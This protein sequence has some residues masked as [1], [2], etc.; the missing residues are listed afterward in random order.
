MKDP[1][2]MAEWTTEYI[3]DL[4]DSAFLFVEEGGE[5]DE[6]GKTVPRTLRHFPIYDIDGNLDLPHLRNAIARIPQSTAE[7]LTEEKM[8]EL[9]EMARKL[10]EEAQPEGDGMDGGEPSREPAAAAPEPVEAAAPE[11]KGDV[12]KEGEMPMHEALLDEM[13]GGLRKLLDRML[14]AV[15]AMELDNAIDELDRC[16]DILW[17]IRSVAG[18]VALAKADGDDPL[19]EMG[20]TINAKRAEVTK[21]E[22]KKAAEPAVLAAEPTPV[23]KALEELTAEVKRIEKAHS[24]EVK[25]LKARIFKAESAVV[26]A[27]QTGDPSGTNRSEVKKGVEGDVFDWPTDMNEHKR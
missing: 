2:Q 24:E 1:K 4:P 21:R 14:M 16:W 12:T 22:V 13:I 27:P 11:K 19:K 17:S 9:Q 6:D 15:D 8:G 7:G 3:N 23:A 18:R 5:M 26:G 10:L 20:A 25:E